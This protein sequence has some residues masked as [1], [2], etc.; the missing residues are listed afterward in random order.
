MA[1]LLV[2]LMFTAILIGAARL[3][4]RELVRPL[5]LYPS[6]ADDMLYDALCAVETRQTSVA[7]PAIAPARSRP[8]ATRQSAHSVPRQSPHRSLAAAA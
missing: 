7:T 8:A 3:L 2:T 4:V 6:C 1:Q 5:T